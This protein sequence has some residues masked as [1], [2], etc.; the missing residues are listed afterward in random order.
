MQDTLNSPAIRIKEA[1]RVKSVK[2]IIAAVSG[3]SGFMNGQLVT[4][5]GGPKGMIV[6]FWE[7]E[8]SV[9]ILGDEAGV[10]LGQEV[11]SLPEEFRIPVG[12]G[13]LGRI[14]NALAE[15]VDGKG[16]VNPPVEYYPVFR[17]APGTM[18]RSGA[19]SCLETGTR[20]ID[21]IV[22]LSK[23]QRQLIIG[24]RMTGKTTIAVDAI[25]NQRDK[26]VV[27]IYCC[28]GK[29]FS[30]LLKV[31]QLLKF[32]GAL[33]YTLVVAAPA[34]ATTAEQYLAPYAAA[35][36]GE[37]F[38]YNGRDVLVVFDDMTKHAWAYR[39]ISLLLE[40]PPGREAYPGDIYYIHSQLMERAGR[41]SRELGSGSMSFFPI[42]DTLQ[43]DVTGFIPSNLISMT[44]GQIYLNSSMFAEGFK[45]AVDFSMSV[46]IIG[47]KTQNP[48]L[49]RL[50][51]G[52]RL[53]YTQFKEL[54]RLTK[55]KSSLSQDVAFKI[56]RGEV[57]TAIFNQDKNKPAAIAELIVL[58]Y[59][60][61]RKI[62]DQLEP[63]KINRFKN[64]I[65]QY[66]LAREPELAKKLESA[67]EL[68]LEIEQ[69]LNSLFV[70][71]LKGM[72]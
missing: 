41:L 15:P 21:A 29:S 60:L 72:E 23:G 63:P 46:S 65:W 24:D 10:R 67:K 40:R 38:F 7:D 14:V 32:G 2:K 58:L 26:G 43:Q 66:I 6:G 35:A 69:V 31:T 50:S 25:L 36:L 19:L 28:I 47:S 54:L 34:S 17:E 39:Q 57:I 22:P 70:G 8:V 53:E 16:P 1:G 71:Y 55:L 30:S 3:L 62:L 20:I 59:A 12:E 42:A 51:G 64:E 48:V 13:F 18:E 9:L 11:Y 44:D 68:T 5:S 37:Y 61:D 4:F 27:C 45:P 33:D 56:R 49:K 52:I